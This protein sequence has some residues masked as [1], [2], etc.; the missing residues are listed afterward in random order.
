MITEAYDTHSIRRQLFA[1]LDLL[2]EFETA[3]S[4]TLEL[5]ARE[6]KAILRVTEVG[7]TPL[8]SIVATVSVSAHNMLDGDDSRLRLRVAYDLLAISHGHMCP[9]DVGF[10]AMMK[11]EYKLTFV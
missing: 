9:A 11:E 7:T 3:G 6:I 4:P 2:A 8:S 10:Y 5:I 1:Y